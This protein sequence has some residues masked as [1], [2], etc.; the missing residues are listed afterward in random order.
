MSEALKNICGLSFLKDLDAY[1]DF[2]LRKFQAEHA[3]IED[4]KMLS[5]KSAS[6]VATNSA[7]AAS[8]SAEAAA[9]ESVDDA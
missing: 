9:D 2:N 1:G 6:A 4:S 5:A 3:V 8:A 7:A